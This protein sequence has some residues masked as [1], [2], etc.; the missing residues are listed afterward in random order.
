MVISV[1]HTV[2]TDVHPTLSCA[3]IS[4][5]IP[6]KMF[7]PSYCFPYHMRRT[8]SSGS[9]QHVRY[10]DRCIQTTETILPWLCVTPNDGIS[11]HCHVLI[12]SSGDHTYSLYPCVLRVGVGIGSDSYIYMGVVGGG[13]R[14]NDMLSWHILLVHVLLNRRCWPVFSVHKYKRG[15]S[16]YS[17]SLKW[18]PSTRHAEVHGT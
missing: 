12:S 15:V 17:P 11:S 5:C 18:L 7:A 8:F 14:G 16:H 3:N 9:N 4:V 6:Y 10:H 2:I 13:G 1:I